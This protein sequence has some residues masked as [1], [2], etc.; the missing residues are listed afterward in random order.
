MNICPV[1]GEAYNEPPAL[2]RADNKML[3]CPDCGLREAMRAAGI[4]DEEQTKVLK[5]VHERGC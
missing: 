4:S 3:V 2:S 1:C 5:A